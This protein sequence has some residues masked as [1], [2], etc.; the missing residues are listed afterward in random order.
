VP[1][2]PVDPALHRMPQPV[3]RPVEGR[4][5][6]APPA[7]GPPVGR[8]VILLRDHRPDAAAAQV[9]AVGPGARGLSTGTRSG[10]VRGRPEPRGG[11]RRP[12]STAPNWGQR[13]SIAIGTNLPFSERGTVYPDPRLVAAIVDRVTFNAHII[14]T[15]TQSYRL[16]TSKTSS[17]KRAS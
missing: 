12:P 13:A 10:R 5:P 4:W 3:D 7:P 11:T 15:G 14:E 1:L 17:R 16:A 8:L 2:E 6:A 9:R